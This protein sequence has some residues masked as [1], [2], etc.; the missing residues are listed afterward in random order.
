GG[1]PS[2]EKAREVRAR[3]RQN[4]SCQSREQWRG[5]SRARA[6]L[7]I[8]AS[9][10]R[11][12]DPMSPVRRGI[13]SLESPRQKVHFG[14]GLRQRDAGLQPAEQLHDVATSLKRIA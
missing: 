12:E 14:A 1:G 13:R 2:Q 9:G 3:D 6:V 11:D 8:D 4:Q 5:S 10:R 7:W